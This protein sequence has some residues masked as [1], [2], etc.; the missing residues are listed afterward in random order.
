MQIL[1]KDIEKKIMDM[2]RLMKKKF[3]KGLGIRKATFSGLFTWK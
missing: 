2:M 1:K 3:E